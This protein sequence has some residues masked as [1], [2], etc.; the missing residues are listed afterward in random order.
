M[1]DVDRLMVVRELQALHKHALVREVSRRGEAMKLDRSLTTRLR[2]RRKTTYMIFLN[3][4]HP[5]D[6]ISHAKVVFRKASNL[7]LST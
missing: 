2:Y 6:A 1:D 7:M 5:R 3:H 4:F